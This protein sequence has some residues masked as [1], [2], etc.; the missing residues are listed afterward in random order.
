M[1]LSSL[2]LFFFVIDSV[3]YRWK[4]GQPEIELGDYL[5]DFTN[6]L[7]PEH[8]YIKEF[9]SAGPKN[10]CYETTSGKQCCK[11]R[12]FTLN[13][14]GQRVLNFHSIRDY[15]LNEIANPVNESRV[16]VTHNPNKIVRDSKEKRI[17]TKKECKKY[18]L[19]F[20]K[21]VLDYDTLQSYPYGYS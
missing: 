9:V 18:R 3:I 17:F 11:V 4:P 21:R 13:S 2:L 16:I 15:V 14:R 7:K 5:G 20:D 10:Y 19:V 12:G 1:F 6:E 8:G